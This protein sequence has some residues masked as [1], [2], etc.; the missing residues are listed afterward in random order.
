MVTA[1]IPL[2]LTAKTINGDKVIN[3]AGEHLGKIEDLMID[4]ENGR[5]AYAVLSF[6]GFL[7]I[8][9]K[10]FAVPWEALSVK[11]DEHAFALDVSKEILEKAEGFDKDDWPLTCEQLATSTREWLAKVY[12]CYG[13]KPYWETGGPGRTEKEIPRETESEKLAPIDKKSEPAKEE[14]K[15]EESKAE[16]AEEARA[17]VARA[18]KARAEKARAAGAEEARVEAVKLE[19]TKVEEVKVEESKVEEVKAEE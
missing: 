6:G 15:A 5:V 11:P 13:Y 2:Y 9:N 14:V 19:G 1:E 3:M 18:E 10:L 16:K 7:G 4:L 12:T 17:E 8:G